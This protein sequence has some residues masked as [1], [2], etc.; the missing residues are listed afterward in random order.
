MVNIEIRREYE[1]AEHFI[2]IAQIREFEIG[3]RWPYKRGQQEMRSTN[4]SDEVFFHPELGPYSYQGTQFNQEKYEQGRLNLINTDDFVGPNFVSNPDYMAIGCSQTYVMG[5]PYNLSWPHIMATQ[6]DVSINAFGMPGAGV[7]EI[8]ANA[9]AMIKR[10]GAPD[11]LCFLLPDILRFDLHGSPT[12]VFD[13]VHRQYV[14]GDKKGRPVP[15]EL[16]SKLLDKSKPLTINPDIVAHTNL[17]LLE[18]FAGF[19]DAMNID[20]RTYS[21]EPYTN[22]AL[23]QMRLQQ[24][25]QPLPEHCTTGSDRLEIWRENG[26]IDPFTNSPIQSLEEQHQGVALPKEHALW[27]SEYCTCGKTPPPNEFVQQV[28][29]WADDRHAT[30][31]PHHGVHTQIHFAEIFGQFRITQ[32]DIDLLRPFWEEAENPPPYYGP[33]TLRSHT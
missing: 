13:Y 10:Y 21:W 17:L 22:F 3:N 25:M 4:G 5:L 14:V 30:N 32:E 12:A 19:C 1:T 2:D 28:W 11:V 23:G 16:Q 18:T 8:I 26:L 27:H 15:L 31:H 33:N 24:Q 6:L 9:T 20:L 7:A 29:T